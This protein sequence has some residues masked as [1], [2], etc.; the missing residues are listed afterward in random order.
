VKKQIVHTALAVLA[1]TCAAG[2]AT[3]TGLPKAQAAT[4]KGTLVFYSAQ[5]YDAAMAKAFSKATGVQVQL[6]DDSTGNIVARIQ[7]ERNNP[8]WDVTW[9]DGDS[10]MQTLDNQGMLLRGW[11]P[12]DVKNY[13]ALGRSLIAPDKSYYP[14]GVTAAAAIGYDT[15][16][17][18]PAKAPK[19]WSDLLKPE[20]KNAVAMNDPSISG[21]TYPYVAGILQM[22]GQAKGKQF[23]SKLKANG[24]HVYPTNDNT[25]QALLEGHVK[26]ITIQDSALI[27]AKVSGDPIRIVYP[28]SGVFTLPG[29]IAIDKHA[30]D[31]ALAKRFVEWVLSPAGQ[32]VSLNVK[33][34]G[35]DSYYNPVIK[36]VKPDAARQQSGIKWVRVNPVYAAHVEN[37]VKLWFHENIG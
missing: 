24:L 4:S 28:S 29:T 32:R 6:V 15:K 26:V 10:T 12:N 18:S 2:L 25:L 9:F 16:F 11:T 17:L 3:T 5:G 27:G 33:N 22:M 31:M 8:H 20:F 19:D 1:V 13:T 21:P 14:G 30:P 36:G 37:S 35:G 34:G 7:A 23:F